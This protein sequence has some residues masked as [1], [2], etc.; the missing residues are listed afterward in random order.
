MFYDWLTYFWPQIQN[1]FTIQNGIFNVPWLFILLQP[2]RFLGPYG[3][4]IVVEVASVFVL[5]KLGKTLQLPVY[6]I[7]LVIFSPPVLFH[8]I[9]GQIDGL[10]MISYLVPSY[11]AAGLAFLKPQTTLGAGIQAIRRRPLS[12]SIVIVLLATAWVIWDWPFS[13]TGLRSKVQLGFNTNLW[14]WSFWPIGI[15][16][17]PL[18]FF[19][20]RRGGMFASPFIFPYAAVQSLVGPMLVVATLPIWVFLP[21][22]VSVWIRWFYMMNFLP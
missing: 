13:V 4:V 18:L 14:I 1:P 3:S 6:R 15:I 11:L 12:L 9:M 8:I 16:T 19:R 20:D 7:V 10:L 17:L 21:I 5:I 2:L 22:W